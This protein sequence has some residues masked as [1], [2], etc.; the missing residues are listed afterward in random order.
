MKTAVVVLSHFYGKGGFSR[1]QIKRMDCA[2]SVFRQE[3]S[4]YL[5]TTGGFGFFNRSSKS[6]GGL[7][8][9]YMV[10]KGTKESQVIAEEKSKN[11]I[12]NLGMALDLIKHLNI[13]K[14]YLVTSADHMPRVKYLME[15][16]RPKKIQ[17][18]Y[19]ISDYWSGLDSVWDFFWHIA[20]W[21]KLGGKVIF[22]RF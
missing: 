10:G 12:E 11:T 15:R 17:V 14:V 8:K 6:L 18:E 4:D 13:Y 2:L 16:I 22:G 7:A 20:G 3:K 9:K 19:V 1:R 5:V 21:V